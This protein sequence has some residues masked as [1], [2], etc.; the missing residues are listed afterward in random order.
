ML[1]IHFVGL[2]VIILLLVA[3]AYKSGDEEAAAP[4]SPYAIE[5]VSASYGLNCN[6]QPAQPVDT[7]AG[8][9]PKAAEKDNVLTQVGR[10][11]NGNLTCKLTVDRATLGDPV[12]KCSKKLT[13]DYRC[14][15]YDRPW[16]AAA[17][18]SE[19]LTI[20]CSTRGG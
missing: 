17:E 6:A 16:R 18:E 13:V 5:V 10:R 1:R 4:D 15:S 8:S 3:I 14:F 11:C 20:D 2:A 19:S 12:P 7:F 9:A